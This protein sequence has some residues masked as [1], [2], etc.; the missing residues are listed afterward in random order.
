MFKGVPVCVGQSLELLT[1]CVFLPISSTF[2]NQSACSS[3][4]LA[5][6][7]AL[8][9]DDGV[10]L[11]SLLP[12]VHIPST[13]KHIFWD[14]YLQ[15]FQYLGACIHHWQVSSLEIMGIYQYILII[16][17]CRCSSS[18]YLF[19]LVRLYQVPCCS[20]SLSVS[21]LTFVNGMD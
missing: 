11:H 21:W 9:L 10:C 8:V 17:V 20:L 13:P 3:K 6:C 12:M 2:Q 7:Y 16:R 18:T 19:T 1:W 15:S 5:F 14:H 4:Y